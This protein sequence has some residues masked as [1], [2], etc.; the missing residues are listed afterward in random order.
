MFL[1]SGLISTRSYTENKISIIDVADRYMGMHEHGH[2]HFGLGPLH[3]RVGPDEFVTRHNDYLGRDKDGEDIY[4]A[5][6]AGNLSCKDAATWK[7]THETTPYIV[8][9][10][11]A[12]MSEPDNAYTELSVSMRHRLESK[13]LDDI[14]SDSRRAEQDGDMGDFENQLIIPNDQIVNGTRYSLHLHVYLHELH[15]NVT[16]QLATKHSNSVWSE[17]YTLVD[18]DRHMNNIQGKFSTTNYSR[19]YDVNND[20]YVDTKYIKRGVGFYHPYVSFTNDSRIKPFFMKG[21]ITRST[22]AIPLEV[23]HLNGLHMYQE[24]EWSENNTRLCECACGNSCILGPFVFCG[25][26]R[27]RYPILPHVHGKT[28]NQEEQPN[29]ETTNANRG[30]FIEIQYFNLA[31]CILAWIYACAYIFRKRFRVQTPAADKINPAT[32]AFGNK[33]PASR[34]NL[35]TTRNTHKP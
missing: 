18:E 12:W 1:K 21:V 8:I 17:Q 9:L 7:D 23:V 31:T 16:M 6:E 22:L 19:Y 15:G 28:V 24:S 10:E 32:T 30:F 34:K 3:M 5:I 4:P 14:I 11:T 25:N 35:T 29:I 2:G 13:R 33:T 27:K 20:E 26:E